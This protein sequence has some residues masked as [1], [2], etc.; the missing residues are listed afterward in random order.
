MHFNLFDFLKF[1]ESDSEHC[2][3]FYSKSL[4]LM[5]PQ[6]PRKLPYGKDC[7]SITFFPSALFIVFCLQG[8]NSW[9]VYVSL[10]WLT[11]LCFGLERGSLAPNVTKNT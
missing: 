8:Y 7:V 3:L 5:V 11:K 6:T 1:L 2:T 10:C 4:Y 9:W